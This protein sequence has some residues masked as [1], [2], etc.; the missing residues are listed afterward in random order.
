MYRKNSSKATCYIKVVYEKDS[1]HET[2]AE[3]EM[4]FMAVC[5]V[6]NV[7]LINIIVLLSWMKCCSFFWENTHHVKV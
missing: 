3:K 7:W 1:T 6:I 2:V 4:Q 5:S